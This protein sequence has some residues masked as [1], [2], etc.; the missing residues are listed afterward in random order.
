MMGKSSGVTATE[1][2]LA[3]FCDKTFLKLWSYP[4]PYKDR[5]VLFNLINYFNLKQLVNSRIQPRGNPFPSGP[6]GHPP[7]GEP[8]LSCTAG[9]HSGGAPRIY[10]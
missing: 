2:M 7:P 1:R 4:N 9:A 6:Q 3:E 10:A 8:G 5:H